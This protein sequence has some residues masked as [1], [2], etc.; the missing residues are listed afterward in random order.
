MFA[1]M[2]IALPVRCVVEH[3]EMINLEIF[4]ETPLFSA[5][6]METGIAATDDCVAREVTYAG[7]AFLRSLNT[8]FFVKIPAT[9]Y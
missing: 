7:I 4:P 1:V 2:D 3:R 9:I 5:H 8:F 6:F